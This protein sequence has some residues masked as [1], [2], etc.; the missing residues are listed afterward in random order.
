MPGKTLSGQATRT[1]EAKR[2]LFE[3]G[4]LPAVQKALNGGGIPFA[5]LHPL[6]HV[7]WD[8]PELIRA[9]VP[10]LYSCSLSLG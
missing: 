10:E 4:P 5:A 8:R 2:V 3:T 7:G 9:V 6:H 1:A